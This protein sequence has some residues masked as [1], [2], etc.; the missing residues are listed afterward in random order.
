MLEHPVMGG[1][2]GC[3]IKVHAFCFSCLCHRAEHLKVPLGSEGIGFATVD[4]KHPSYVEAGL[5]VGRQMSI[6]DDSTGACDYDR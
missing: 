2:R 5:P 3:H 1:R 4:V 6:V